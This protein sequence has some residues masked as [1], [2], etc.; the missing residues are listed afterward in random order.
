MAK[1][2]NI[3][4][5]LLRS[6]KSR[7]DRY[8]VMDTAV[9]GFGVRVSNGRKTFI[10]LTRYPGSNNPTRRVLGAQSARDVY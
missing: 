4:D 3:T 9:S 1:R 5:R 2:T 7:A 6:L 10:L 8:D